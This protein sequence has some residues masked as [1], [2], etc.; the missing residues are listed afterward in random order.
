MH[1]LLSNRRGCS[2][3]L[4][5]GVLSPHACSITLRLRGWEA[6]SPLDGCQSDLLLALE[7]KGKF[8]ALI[9]WTYERVE[10]ISYICCVQTR[11]LR[12]IF[13]CETSPLVGDPY[14]TRVIRLKTPPRYDCH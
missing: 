5:L 4:F 10:N 14:P 11:S 3:V 1:A 7:H 9:R 6:T 2:Q 12:L 8:I 13:G